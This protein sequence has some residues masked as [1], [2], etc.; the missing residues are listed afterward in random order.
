[1]QEL[2]Q[3]VRS[4]RSLSYHYSR[5][6]LSEFRKEPVA[7]E[8]REMMMMFG[9]NGLWKQGDSRKQECGSGVRSLLPSLTVLFFIPCSRA[10]GSIVIV[11]T[12]LKQHSD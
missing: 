9:G 3:A 10:D 4:V 12:A 11:S 7:H 2:T 1:M 5:G 6:F 8:I